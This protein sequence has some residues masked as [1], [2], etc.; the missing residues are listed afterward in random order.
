VTIDMPMVSNDEQAQRLA[1]A[2]LKEARRARRHTL[3]LPPEYWALEPGD[4]V[5]WTS[6]RNGYDA[7]LFRVDGIVD[8]PNL[9]VLVDL[10]ETDPADYDWDGATEFVT[11]ADGFLGAA[12]PAIGSTSVSVAPHTITVGG[13]GRRPAILLSW[14]NAPGDVLGL[15][16]QVRVAA[17]GAMVAEGTAPGIEPSTNGSTPISSGLVADTAYEVRARWVPSTRRVVSWSSWLT[18]TTPD[19]RMGV[20]EF[21]SGIE[22]VGVVATAP[23]PTVKSTEVIYY[24]PDGKLYRWDGTAYTAEV[25]GA[26]IAAGSITAGKVA[27]GAISATEISVTDLSAISANLGTIQV[28]SANI[29]S[30]AVDTFALAGEAVTTGK[31]ASE[32]TSLVRAATVTGFNLTSSAFVSVLA[33]NLPAPA[34]I[35]AV[36]LMVQATV[37][38]TGAAPNLRV[39]L[40]Y[41][42][43]P[44]FFRDIYEVGTF[45][46]I[47]PQ[48]VFAPP[49]QSVSV[50]IVGRRIGLDDATVQAANLQALQVTS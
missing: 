6:E 41:P 43:S 10:T 46:F 16:W 21:A 1:K 27:A 38:S 31:I 28:G 40:A 20:A 23:L 17:T 33:Y 30:L 15:D 3:T 35:S 8:L 44:V 12:R 4:V 49:G 14:T 47:F 18:V 5:A 39:Q 19:V 34:R 11:V 7:K 25:D 50:A 37:T 48:W 26:D 45:D 22:P 9:D 42:G 29:G 24:A 13:V 2:A 32:N 36:M